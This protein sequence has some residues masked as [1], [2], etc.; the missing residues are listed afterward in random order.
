MIASI[1]S[2]ILIPPCVM[3]VL[4]IVQKAN[5]RT[6][7]TMSDR[8]FVV[9]VPNAVLS[10]GILCAFMSLMVMLGFTVFSSELPPLPFYIVFGLFF[11]LGMYLVVKTIR[12]RVIVIEER[13]NVFPAFGR[14]YSFS[15][16]DIVSVIRQTK[17]NRMHSER[18]VVKTSTGKKLIVE[19]S[20]VSYKR[21]LNRIMSE[22]GNGYSIR[23]E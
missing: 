18:I 14:A 21:F 17:G 15:F 10:I 12:F 7:K 16:G 22:T 1:F 3:A 13:I 5:S 6:S 9:T 8:Q 23:F 11:W 4:S 19:S 2:A 20:E